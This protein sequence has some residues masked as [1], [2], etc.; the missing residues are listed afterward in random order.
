MYRHW[1][2]VLVPILLLVGTAVGLG[3]TRP[4]KYTATATL[5]VG[6]VYVSNPAGVSTVIEAT[7]TLAGV[8]SRT[9]HATRVQQDVAQ[10][11]KQAGLPVSGGVSATPLPAS[12]LIKVTADATS[13]TGATALANAGAD[14]LVDYVNHE[15]R[16]TDVTASLRKRYL[17]AALAYRQKKDTSDRLDRRYQLHRTARNKRARDAAGAAA[18]GAQL[19]LQTLQTSYQQ[20]VQGGVA[21]AAV[22]SFSR[23]GAAASDRG[24][25][26]QILVF[27][28]LLGGIAGG[29]ALALLR[30]NRGLR[31]NRAP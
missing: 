15:V 10:R 1:P 22:E 6:H 9:I 21:S 27:V 17:Q 23:A 16:A 30:A 14:A 24:R 8:Y 2:V 25:T 5:Q 3:L 18:D 31:S 20:I 29:V 12:P 28:G 4:P 11:L 19:T 13:A 7:Q 26:M